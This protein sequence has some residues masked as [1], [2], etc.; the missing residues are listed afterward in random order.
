MR[1]LQVTIYGELKFGGPPQKIFA[2]SDGLASRG[3]HVEIA[4]FHSEMPQGGM[5]QKRGDVTLHFLAWGGRSLWQLPTDW[6]RLRRAVRYADIV[7]VYGLYNLLCPLA[8]WVARQSGKPFILEPLG[9]FVPR[10]RSVRGKVI[11]NRLLTVPMAHAA[12]RVVATSAREAEELA[13]LVPSDKL[14]M[15]R[16]G[17]DLSAFQNLPTGANFRSRFGL[18]TD[19]RIVLFV[20]RISPIKNLEELMRAFALAKLPQTRLVLV[21]PEL[22][23]E[24]AVRL[25][26]LIEELRLSERVMLAGELYERDKLSAL[27]AAALFVLPSTYESYGNAAAEAIAAGVPVLITKGCGIAPQIDGRGGLVVEPEAH[28]LAKGLETLLND[29]MQRNALCAR[30][31]EIMSELSWEE[32]LQ[33]TEEVYQAILK[34]HHVHSRY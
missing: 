28:A 19:E 32:P 16:N 13:L 22:E 25:R 2:L 20:G 8:A 4:T 24:Y 7:H 11:Y 1:V 15:R 14:V 23:P 27:A 33:Q 5:P 26:A 30:R 3:H 29:E 9:M 21:G 10:A 31:S 6:R 34:E 17:L 18:G 12:A